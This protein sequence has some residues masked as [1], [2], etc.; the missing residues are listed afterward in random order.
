MPKTAFA[1]A[2]HD[3]PCG[4]FLPA[5]QG[6]VHVDRSRRLVGSP[7]RLALDAGVAPS[8]ASGTG[9]V[10]AG[11]AQRALHEFLTRGYGPPSRLVGEG[12]GRRA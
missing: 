1:L 4:F 7:L 6:C 11:G 3:A 9:C 8:N 5:Q 2:R 10:A 12:A